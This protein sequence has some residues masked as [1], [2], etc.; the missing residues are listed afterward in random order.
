MPCLRLPC[1]CCAKLIILYT[2]DGA[3]GENQYIY[4]KLNEFRVDSED[5]KKPYIDYRLPGVG[6]VCRSSWILCAGFPNR[7]NSRVRRLEA[8][9]RSSLPLSPQRLRKR[10]KALHASDYAM[11]FLE[12]FILKNSQRSP[13]TTEL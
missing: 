5:G 4:T 8:K 13:V 3:K 9:I 12:N 6:I 7:N 11:A 10:S 1:S 2:T